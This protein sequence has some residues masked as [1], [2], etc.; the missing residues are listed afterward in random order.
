MKINTTQQYINQSYTANNANTT[1]NTSADQGKQSQESL[2]DSI[3]LSSTT[4]DLQKIS[5]AAAEKSDDRTQQRALMVEDLKQ[6][7]QANQYTVNAEQVAEK[8]IG[9]I[10]NEVG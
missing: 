4:K 2:S 7:V 5:A 1:A 10:M 8:M 6:Q 3:N 9:S